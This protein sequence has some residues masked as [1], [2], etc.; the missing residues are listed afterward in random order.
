MDRMDDL[1][2]RRERRIEHILSGE[3]GRHDRYDQ[4]DGHDRYDRNNRYDYQGRD[5]DNMRDP[6][7][8]HERKL[9]EDPEYEWNYKINPWKHRPS[10]LER[11]LRIQA[12]VSVVLFAAIWALFQ[13][14]HPALAGSQSFISSALTEELPMD[15]Y[16]AWY[17]E[18][19]G[20]AP[21][22]IPALNRTSE[23]ARS[24]NAKQAREYVIP[25]AGTVVEPFGSVRAGAGII[26]RTG[27]G[28]EVSAMDT[29]LVTFAG[30]TADTGK[31]VVVRHPGGVQTVYGRLEQVNVKK[32]EW[33]EA[34]EAI[35]TVKGVGTQGKDGMLY[36]AVNRSGGFVDPQDVVPLE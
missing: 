10:G 14:N 5:D 22:F 15:R 3:G 11:T 28:A 16:A 18:H 27:S 1:R 31:T 6:Y 12:T 13:W 25:A 32:D 17:K 34:G 35:G 2:K 4:Y 19:L 23:E 24:A 7:Y 33:V 21:S 20:S 36:F 29:G 9:R 26:I 30:E 8:E